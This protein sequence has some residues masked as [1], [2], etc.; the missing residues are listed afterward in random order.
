V[1]LPAHGIV[2]TGNNIEPGDC[3][4]HLL[5]H[6]VPASYMS[7]GR[8]RSTSFGDAR[9]GASMTSASIIK[10]IPSDNFT[11]RFI[12]SPMQLSLC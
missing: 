6:P 7:S 10:L 9:W 12:I 5:R 11:V 8:K 4:I 1:V 2:R 3:R